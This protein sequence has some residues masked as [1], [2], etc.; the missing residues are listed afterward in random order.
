VA[1]GVGEPGDPFGRGGERDA[2]AGQAGADRDGDR[3]VGLA[4]A[5]RA[6]Q[7]DVLARVQEVELAEMLDDLALDA[8]LE[9]EVKLLERLARREACGLDAALAAVA[10][11]GGDLG[12]E[13]RLGEALIA[14]LL[15]A[16]ALGELGERAGGGRRL[17]RP[18]QVRKL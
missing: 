9:G 16:R 17:Q 12:R 18:E 11:P 6:E 8:A 15:L 5:G 1:F 7:D 10:V 2:L 3:Q 13:Q 4:G 14:P